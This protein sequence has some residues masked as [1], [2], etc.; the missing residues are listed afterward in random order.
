MLWMLMRVSAFWGSDFKPAL[1]LTNCLCWLFESQNSSSVFLKTPL[2]AC[3]A[4][5]FR[6][7]I[8]SASRRCCASSA[9]QWMVSFMR[10]S[11]PRFVMRAQSP[12][13]RSSLSRF[14]RPTSAGQRSKEKTGATMLSDGP[15]GPRGERSDPRNCP[16]E[17][18]CRA[19]ATAS[20]ESRGKHKTRGE[21]RPIGAS[22][23]VS[24]SVSRR[25]ACDFFERNWNS[26]AS[27]GRLAR[28]GWPGMKAWGCQAR[29]D[30][31]KAPLVRAQWRTADV[32]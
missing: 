24:T 28:D 16:S 8:D 15:Q 20:H 9:D 30:P 2:G 6:S 22:R 32:H 10:L 19:V 29:R 23:S 1:V 21:D 25:V 27:G 14:A 12:C 11:L 7:A 26:K 17:M 5:T 4:Y 31:L 18:T 13:I 3:S